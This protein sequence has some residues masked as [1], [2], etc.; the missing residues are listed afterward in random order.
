MKDS[1][2]VLTLCLM[3]G[4]LFYAAGGTI[5][6]PLPP[7]P[8]VPPTYVPTPGIEDAVATTLAEPTPAAHAIEDSPT[9][10]PPATNTPTSTPTL[11]DPLP[12]ATPA[13]TSVL[14]SPIVCEGSSKGYLE[15]ERVISIPTGSFLHI[16]FYRH[17]E[18][19]R[20]TLLPPGEYEVSLLSGGYWRLGPAC[21][22]ESALVH[23]VGSVSGAKSRSIADPY[24]V[25]WSWARDHGYLT[26]LSAE[27]PGIPA[28]L[29]E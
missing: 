7:E 10:T 23:V 27:D 26:V 6:R 19:E 4:I 18:P 21:S 17:G 22:V 24:Y 11:L 15:Q 8:P 29:S 5:L 9:S 3:A 16:Q 25:H 20:T 28:S 14:I 13:S 2:A 1:I 12:T